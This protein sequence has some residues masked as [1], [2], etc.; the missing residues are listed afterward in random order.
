MSGK[1]N[2]EP[3]IVAMAGTGI[4]SPEEK[5]KLEEDKKIKEKNRKERDGTS[6]SKATIERK[7]MLQ[8]SYC[9]LGWA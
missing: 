4:N 2:C 9:L 6:E 8:P 7:S 5:C 1:N 3:G